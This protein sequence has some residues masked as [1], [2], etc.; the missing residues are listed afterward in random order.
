M[1]MDDENQ[2]TVVLT[3]PP[4]DIESALVETA[5]E[6]PGCQ[7]TCSWQEIRQF[8]QRLRSGGLG[9]SMVEEKYEVCVCLQDNMRSTIH[10]WSC[11]IFNEQTLKFEAWGFNSES[12]AR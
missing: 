12:R 9:K 10:D 4:Q 6:H 8:Q 7:C 2:E 1:T 3:P 5:K 11:Y